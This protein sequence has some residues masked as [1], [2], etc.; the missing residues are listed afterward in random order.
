MGDI[1]MGNGIGMSDRGFGERNSGLGMERELKIN[2]GS[3]IWELEWRL[4]YV[5]GIGGWRLR[6]V[7][8]KGIKIGNPVDVYVYSVSVNG[9]CT[10]Q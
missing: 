2:F 5:L 9:Y 3:R 6:W 7:S 8:G 10:V 1:R 4:G